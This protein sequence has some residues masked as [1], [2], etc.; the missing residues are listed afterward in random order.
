[1]VAELLAQP[2]EGAGVIA[3]VGTS[4]I[5]FSLLAY[6]TQPL[7][8]RLFPQK[9]RTSLNPAVQSRNE[10]ALV[11]PLRKTP[12]KNT[13]RQLRSLQP[14]LNAVTR[15]LPVSYATEVILDHY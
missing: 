12:G 14:V 15:A 8:T 10:N 13:G 5:T 7:P 3:V 1:M 11:Q 6:K 4:A 9:S 2:Y